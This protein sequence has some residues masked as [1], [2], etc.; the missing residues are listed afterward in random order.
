MSTI[1]EGCRRGM[2]LLCAALVALAAWVS[3]TAL[4]TVALEPTRTVAVFAPASASF[5][6][7]VQA[8]ARLVDAGNGFILV[9]GEH[10]GFVRELYAGGGWLVLPAPTS[11]CRGGGGRLRAENGES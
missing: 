2:R 9:Q 6:A 10:R 11:G 5:S 3:L 4:A 7:L 1:T 8:D